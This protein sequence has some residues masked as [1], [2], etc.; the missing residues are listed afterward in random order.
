MTLSLPYLQ[1][2]TIRHRSGTTVED[3]PVSVWP[4]SP[5]SG[6]AGVYYDHEG[7]CPVDYFS[8]VSAPNVFFDID[9]WSYHVVS[10]VK[11]MLLPHVAL[12]LRRQST[13]G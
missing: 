7:E 13:H 11:H 2:G 3:V 8:D 9:G 1:R 4:S 6:D 12:L 5:R 10:A